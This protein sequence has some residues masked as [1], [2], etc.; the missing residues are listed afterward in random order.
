MFGP[1]HIQT[2]PFL[3]TLHGQM[4]FFVKNNLRSYCIVPYLIFFGKNTFMI[5]SNVKHK[6]RYGS[7]KANELSQNRRCKTARRIILVFLFFPSAFPFLHSK[8]DVERSF[9]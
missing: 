4:F 2:R 3:E 6:W 8:E 9:A 1:F 5:A 7:Q